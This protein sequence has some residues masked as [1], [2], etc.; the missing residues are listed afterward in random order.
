MSI[1]FESLWFL[2]GSYNHTHS[3]FGQPAELLSTLIVRALLQQL[4]DVHGPVE[5]ATGQADTDCCLMFV[6]CQHP[7]FDPSQPQS[8]NGLLDFVLESEGDEE[9]W[10]YLAYFLLLGL[11]ERLT[12]F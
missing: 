2:Y 4:K 11:S 10:K 8:L 7:H 5:V 12:Y 3:P 1:S 9:E 6:P